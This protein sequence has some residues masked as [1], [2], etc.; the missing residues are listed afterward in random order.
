MTWNYRVCKYEVN[1][2]TLYAVREVYYDDDGLPDGFCDASVDNWESVEDLRGT[3]E[4]MLRAFDAPVLSV[5]KDLTRGDK[6]G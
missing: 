4:H 6:N 5:M 1:D 3:L 2:Q